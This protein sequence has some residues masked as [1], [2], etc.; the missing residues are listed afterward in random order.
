MF[1]VKY[2]LD[3]SV[4]RYKVRLVAKSNIQTHGVGYHETFAPMAKMNTQQI[5]MSSAANFN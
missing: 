5:L 4:E 2:I 3:G 1:V